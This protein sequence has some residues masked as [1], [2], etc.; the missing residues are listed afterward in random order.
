MQK[1]LKKTLNIG[2]PILLGAV[3]LW[4]MY[5][6]FDFHALERTLAHDMQWSW[7]LVSLIFGVTAQIFRGL[8]WKQSLAPLG[9]FPKTSHCIHAIF[10]SY[11]SSLL[12]PRIG[13]ITRC[14]MLTR[15]DGTSFGKS[16]GTVITER[17]VDSLAILLMLLATFF[18]QLG[19]LSLFF[20]KTGTNLSK[21]TDTFS[22]TGW[23]VTAICAL[24]TAAFLMLSLRRLQ[25][26][27]RFKQLVND[28]KTGIL[29]L[30][31]IAHPLLYAFYTVGIWGSYF[32]HFY[33]TFYCFDFTSELGFTPAFVAFVIGSIAVIVPTP[34][35]MG[36]WHFAVKT[37]LTLYGVDATSAETFVLVVHTIQTALIPL[38]GIYSLICVSFMKPLNAKNE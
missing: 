30:R 6:G 3:I 7:M 22:A 21:W 10:L 27:G 32:L 18:I 1:I 16:I 26:W 31:N 33:L 23:L 38:L 24:A 13:E 20:R 11:A 25:I 2:L 37:I 5:R 19:P 34:N 35:G 15:Y 14:G 17:I 9:E 28:I 29:S 12:I 36:P 4:W 8:R